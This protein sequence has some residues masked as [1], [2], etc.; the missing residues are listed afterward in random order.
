[1]EA[2]SPLSDT[3]W[4][5]QSNFFP[6][7]LN[8]ITSMNNIPDKTRITNRLDKNYLR[9]LGKNTRCHNIALIHQLKLLGNGRGGVQVGSNER[10]KRKAQAQP[11][12]DNIHY[13]MENTA[14]RSMTS[15]PS[16]VQQIHYIMRRYSQTSSSLIFISQMEET[17]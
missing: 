5:P 11:T 2:A 9:A 8:C 16:R 7:T 4:E 14:V 3:F 17:H 6:C 15:P 10:L 13:I 1:M 12:S